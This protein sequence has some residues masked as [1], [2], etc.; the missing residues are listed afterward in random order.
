[1]KDP[2]QERVEAGKTYTMDLRF[3]SGGVVR[4]EIDF[5]KQKELPSKGELETFSRMFELFLSDVAAAAG[6]ATREISLVVPD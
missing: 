2:N 4:V 6:Y 5:T 3:D 1:M